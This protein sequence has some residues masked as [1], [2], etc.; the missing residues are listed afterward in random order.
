M[1]L[2]LGLSRGIDWINARIGRLAT[3]CVLIAVLISAG[4]AASR[5]TLSLSSNAWLEVQWYLFSAMFLLGAPYTL[6]VN[7]HVRVDVIFGALSP[8]TQAWIDLI[9]GILFLMPATVILAWMC[10]P[11]FV[12]SWTIHEMSGDAGGLVRWPVKLLMPVGFALLA[13]Q[14]V[15]EIIKRIAILAGHGELATKYEKPLQ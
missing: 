8:R 12:Q 15:S 14:G 10:W 13:L 7:E 1:R 2:L 3:W 5:Y 4:N 11:Y 9:G 6:K